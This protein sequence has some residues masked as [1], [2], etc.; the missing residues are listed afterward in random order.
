MVDGEYVFK[1]AEIGLAHVDCFRRY[2]RALAEDDIKTLVVDNT[3]IQAWE[4]APY[5]MA[6][7]VFGVNNITVF[8]IHAPLEL[9]FAR[10]IHNVPYGVIR[11]MH[12]TFATRLLPNH[13]K[14]QHAHAHPE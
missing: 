6:A 12:S 7:A 5:Y 1:P 11:K 3:N 8:E 13:W 9:C 14:V 4:I 10:N 2:L